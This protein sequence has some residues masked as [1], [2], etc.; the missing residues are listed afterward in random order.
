MQRNA[1]RC[2]VTREIACRA[3]CFTEVPP[4]RQQTQPG[5]L[6]VRR[7]SLSGR[8]GG[9]RPQLNIA[10]SSYAILKA[11][12]PRVLHI[13]EAQYYVASE[14][15][16]LLKLSSLRD[17]ASGP[18]PTPSHEE[19]HAQVRARAFDRSRY[20]RPRS[21]RRRILADASAG[22]CWGVATTAGAATTC[23][24]NTAGSTLWATSESNRSPPGRLHGVPGR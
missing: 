4:S 20:S 2:A 19:N 8:E 24:C 12:S 23:I 9:L 7:V 5:D 3:A 13:A 1:F 15:G 10:S 14:W 6:S 18:P 17:R 21:R 11:K 22:A 16:V